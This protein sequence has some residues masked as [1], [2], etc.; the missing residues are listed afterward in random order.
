MMISKSPLP[1]SSAA[2]N[3]MKAVQ[4]SGTKAERLLRQAL[5][6][7][8]LQYETDAR[9][10]PNSTRRADILFPQEKIAVF[11]DGCFW[12]GCLIHGTWAKANAEFW[13]KKIE[14]NKRRDEDTNFELIQSGWQVVRVW[15]HEDPNEAAL[16]IS[17]LLE[18]STKRC[19]VSSSITDSD[20]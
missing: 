17:A 16:R 19:D 6:E 12:H 8:G 9:P 2:R 7:L 20:R 15:E 13:R 5:D 1:S 14:A 11:V 10:I 18:D 4:R 3:R